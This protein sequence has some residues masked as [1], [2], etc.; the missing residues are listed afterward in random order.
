ML[1]KKYNIISNN[2]KEFR[3]EKGFSQRELCQKLDLLGV[4]SSLINSSSIFL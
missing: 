1:N 3:K 4:S 2:F